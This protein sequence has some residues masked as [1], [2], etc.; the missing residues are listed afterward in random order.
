MFK[1][2]WI[3]FLLQLEFLCLLALSQSNK[4]GAYKSQSSISPIKEIYWK[5][6]YPDLSNCKTSNPK[7]CYALTSVFKN[8]KFITSNWLRVETCY[9]T[10]SECKSCHCITQQLHALLYNKSHLHSE[11]IVNA[12]YPFPPYIT[13]NEAKYYT[14]I[15]GP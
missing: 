1:H 4:I 11:I 6:L 7:L 9:V 12:N 2:L 10:F 8:L 5:I 13:W 14:S 3:L 15:N